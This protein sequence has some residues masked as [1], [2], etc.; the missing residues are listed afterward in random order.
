M[1]VLRYCDNV[2]EMDDGVG[3]ILEALKENGLENSTIV[4]FASDH[5]GD[6]KIINPKTGQRIGGFNK[7]F[8]GSYFIKS[9]YLPT[10]LNYKKYT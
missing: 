7:K 9:K 4:Y 6:I 5:G 2:E 1:F 3:I 10:K 8:K